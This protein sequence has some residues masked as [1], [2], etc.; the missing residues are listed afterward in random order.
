MPGWAP[1][2]KTISINILNNKKA[3]F[4][5]G[6][7]NYIYVVNNFDLQDNVAVRYSLKRTIPLGD[8]LKKTQR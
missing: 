3:T 4:K 2:R 5:G 1:G 8:K 7:F 6:F